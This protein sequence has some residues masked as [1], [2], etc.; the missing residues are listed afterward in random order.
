M[1]ALYMLNVPLS[2]LGPAERHHDS[3]R[4][5]HEAGH[6]KSRLVRPI[7]KLG[8]ARLEGQDWQFRHSYR[9]IS[10]PF[11]ATGSLL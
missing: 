10:F 4:D 2:L 3:R 8:N 5:E 11:V 6:R 1:Y 7:R 9:F